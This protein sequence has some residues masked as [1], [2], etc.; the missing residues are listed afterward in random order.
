[1][2][3]P[4]LIWFGETMSG[5]TADGYEVEISPAQFRGGSVLKINPPTGTQL[6]QV[7]ASIGAAKT[8]AETEIEHHRA[9]K[10]WTK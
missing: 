6:Y 3:A 7:C 10:G 5:K 1:M 8:N 9:R 2:S 4:R